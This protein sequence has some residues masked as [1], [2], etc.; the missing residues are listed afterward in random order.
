[1]QVVLLRQG[2]CERGSLA[3][4]SWVPR[5][6]YIEVVTRASKRISFFFSEEK[7]T[8]TQTFWSGYIRVG[9]GSSTWRMGAKKFGMSVE[10]QGSQTFWRTK[11]PIVARQATSVAT[12]PPGTATLFKSNLTC[13]TP[14]MSWKGRCYR[15][16]FRGG[17]ARFSCDTPPN[18]GN[19]VRQSVARQRSV[20]RL[21]L[22][23][24]RLPSSTKTLHT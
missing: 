4:P 13:D 16:L 19:V 3:S 12:T 10:N 15:A 9:W 21:L 22:R 23:L 18:S 1:M 20:T 5:S 7:G 14:F 6:S 24:G 11:C 2:E 8:Q 17:V